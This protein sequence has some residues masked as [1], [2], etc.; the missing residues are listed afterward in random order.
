MAENA[1]KMGA[2]VLVA[3]TSFN[4]MARTTSTTGEVKDVHVSRFNEYVERV[5]AIPAGIDPRKITTGIVYNA[6]GTFSHVPTEVFEEEGIWYARLNSLT[7]SDYSVL[8]NPVNVASVENHWSKEMVNDMASRLVIKNPQSFTP[9]EAISRGE[10]AEYITKAL[11]LYRTGVARTQ[12]FSDVPVTHVLADAITTATEYGIISGYPDGS[13]KPEGIISREEAMTMYARAMDIVELM[14]INNN[15][16]EGYSDKNQIAAWAYPHVEKAVSV[17]VFNGRTP[18]TINPKGT[19]TY[20]EA[21]TA[22]RNLL[23]KAILIND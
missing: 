9:D 7:N 10:F 22:I 6:D 23:L 2:E 18:D 21:A 20:A 17:G 14:A 11:G 15:R 12:V 1:R 4:I 19:F 16:V 13:F 8:W 3:P 5:M